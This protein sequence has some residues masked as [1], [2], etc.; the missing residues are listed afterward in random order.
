MRQSYAGMV[1]IVGMAMAL[2][3][4]GGCDGPDNAGEPAVVTPTDT[5]TPRASAIPDARP[6]NV[7][8]RFARMALQ[9]VHREYPNKIS[10][11]LTSDEDAEPPHKL[12]PAFYGCFD[13]HSAVHG[14]WLLVRLLK[15]EPDGPMADAIIAALDKSFTKA[16]LD[17][18]LAYFSGEDRAGFE[19]PYGMAWYLQLV[20]EL[21]ESDDPKLREW[22]ERQRPLESAIV[23]QIKDWVPKL[24]YPI[25][26]GTHNQSAFAFGLI[27]DYARAVDEPGLEK[28]ITDKALAFHGQDT[29]CPIG[30]E[31]SG[32]DFLSPCLMEADLMRRVMGPEDFARWLGAFLPQIPR[33]GGDEWLEPGVV[34]DASD[35]K[36]VHLDGLNLSRAWALEGIA[37]ALPEDDRRR[38]ALLA[39]AARHRE[40]GIAAVSDKD[41]AGGHWLASFATYLTTRRGTTGP[42]AIA[43][44]APPRANDEASGDE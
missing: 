16:N 39:A 9:C 37:N 5:E 25:R 10:H 24:A 43:R 11:V 4:L 27:L 12:T 13:W 32:E 1:A 36:L 38:P 6:G 22:R 20:A 14:H 41:Y 31:P 29:N 15:A 44:A 17:G 34:L 28:L 19:R 40:T 7:N 30:Y 21:D 18:E 35:G 42:G 2:A 8:D 23:A 26:I 33:T 3:A